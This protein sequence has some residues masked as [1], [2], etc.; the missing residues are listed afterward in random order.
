MNFNIPQVVETFL[1][2]VSYR[3]KVV[4]LR[5]INSLLKDES[6]VVRDWFKNTGISPLTIFYL[7]RD[8]QTNNIVWPCCVVCGKPLTEDYIL[9]NKKVKRCCSRACYAI[10]PQRLNKVKQTS[11]ERYGV[12]DP[13]RSAAVEEKRKTA[14]IQKYGLASPAKDPN[15]R[16]KIKRTNNERYG[17]NYP[18]N[19][20]LIQTKI[21]QAIND[22]YGV[23]NVGKCD[24]ILCRR[25]QSFRKNNFDHY[26]NTVLKLHNIELLTDQQHYM[27][28][29]NLDFKC[30]N[31]NYQWTT[32]HKVAQQIICPICSANKFTSGGE[33]S[34]LEYIQSIYD[35]LIIRHDRSILSNHRELD[36]FLPEKNLAFEYNGNWWHNELY[37]DSSYHLR[38]TEQCQSAGIRLIHIFENQWMDSEFQIKSIIK[39]SL[40]LYDQVIYARSCN[41]ERLTPQEYREFVELNHLSAPINASTRIGLK[42]KGHLVAAAGFGQS[43]YKKGE[44]ELYRFCNKAGLRVVGGLSR[45]MCHCGFDRVVSYV[46]LAH[47]TGAGYVASGFDL[48]G[49]TKPNYRYTNGKILIDRINCQ[50]HKLATLLGD[51]YDPSMTEGENMAKRG[52]Y[53][54]YDCGN[55]KMEWVRPQ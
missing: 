53:K 3:Y 42:Y 47:F 12:D 16:D 17:G 50:K 9:K 21:K 49:K 48:V 41:V 34:L 8:L 40:G 1:Q 5:F 15:I 31:C 14:L 54:I 43:R 13:F 23:D 27:T 18:F 35:G 45:L 36:I 24:E 26:K 46:D 44:I 25:V 55:L 19:S 4:Q 7:W 28:D 6:D 38:K 51:D 39:S 10:D 22:K 52:F 37:C 11:N 20:Q 32:N 29:D 2:K 33:Y 30:C